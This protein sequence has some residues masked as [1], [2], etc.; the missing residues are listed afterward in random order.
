MFVMGFTALKTSSCGTFRL[1]EFFLGTLGFDDV[2]CLGAGGGLRSPGTKSKIGR[3]L[4]RLLLRSARRRP[5][6]SGIH[7]PVSIVTKKTRDQNNVNRRVPWYLPY[8]PCTF[9]WTPFWT[10]RSSIRVRAGLSNPDALRIC[11]AFIQSSDRRRII[12][13]PSTL[14]SYTGT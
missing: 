1:L 4:S 13:S 7:V 5:S 10:S 14:N 2:E 8:P 6:E 3:N 11:V 12:L 9:S